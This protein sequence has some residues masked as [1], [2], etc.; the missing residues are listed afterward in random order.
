M[1][2]TYNAP[3]VNDT[4]G[5]LTRY[6]LGQVVSQ[7]TYI[8]RN[9][10]NQIPLEEPIKFSVQGNPGFPLK[11]ALEKNYREL[12]GRDEEMLVNASAGI[13]IRLE[14]TDYPSWSRQIKTHDWSRGRRPISRAKL[15]TEIA[16]VVDRFVK[17]MCKRSGS[18]NIDTNRLA[19]TAL[20][21]VSKS[22]WQ[23]E[24]FIISSEDGF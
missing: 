24:L 21:Q 4:T 17:D 8:D 6:T 2:S 10:R 20:K 15:A 12:D 19:L 9:K 3:Q 18:C 1:S 5:P 13:S 7:V 14:S 16:K 23:P 11:H 22:S